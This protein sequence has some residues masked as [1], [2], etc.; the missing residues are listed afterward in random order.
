MCI[1]LPGISKLLSLA[2]CG[3]TGRVVGALLS[4][5]TVAVGE[6]VG[7][8]GGEGIAGNAVVSGVDGKAGEDCEEL[9][10]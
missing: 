3:A 7:L 1:S 8:T 2:F 10:L 6:T 4:E 5:F 9:R